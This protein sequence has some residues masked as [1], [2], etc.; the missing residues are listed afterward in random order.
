VTT[1]SASGWTEF[2]PLL[3][4]KRS[5]D[6]F[7]AHARALA[8]TPHDDEQAQA[9]DEL[10]DLFVEH[11][12]SSRSAERQS[13]IAAAL[14]LTDLAM[15]RWRIRVRSNRVAVCAPLQVADDPSAEKARIRRQELLKRDAQLRQEAVQ[16]FLRSM[17]RPR[18]FNKRFTSVF[19]LMRDGR[20]LV[21]ALQRAREYTGEDWA[22]ALANVVDPYLQFV[23]SED[24]TCAFTGLRLMDVWRYFRHTWTNQY[25]TVPGRSMAFLVRDRMAPFH[26]IVGI[27]ALSSPVMQIRER[28]KWIGWHAESFLP[29]IR[30]NP[31]EEVAKWL[32]AVVDKAIDEIYVDDLREDGIL[33]PRD[34][35]EPSDALIRR[36][37]KEAEGWR[38]LHYR[39]SRSR[40]HKPARTAP[41]DREFWIAKARTH[42]FRSKRALGLA[43][44]LRV[45]ATLRD[46]FGRK[47]TGA[48]L[49][50]LAAT[51]EGSDAIRKIVKK[52]KAD[53]VGIAVADITVCGAIQP[54]NAILGGKLV[55]MLAASPEVVAQYRHRYANAES[56]IAS[57]IAGRMV[58]RPPTLVLLGTTSLYGSGS[59]QYNRIKIPC[60]R[61]DGPADQVI[62]YEELGQS[63][64]FGTSQFSEET[65]DALVDVAQQSAGGQRVNSI[66]GEG[67]SPKLRKIRQGL[68][69]LGLPSDILLRHHRQRV[70]YAVSLVRNL[71]DYLLGID[72]EPEYLFSIDNTP[73]ASAG[74][75]AWWRERWLRNRI[76][77]D[78]VLAEV[79]KHTLVRPISHGARVL[80]PSAPL[81]QQELV[82]AEF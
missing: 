4:N 3:R 70:V 58:V 67:V 27:G 66:F 28:D 48:K 38:A 32:V 17:E 7:L 25:T 22:S 26:P 23:T 71:R 64:A 78:E 69:V 29:W 11:V 76:R 52:A 55:A 34:L 79:A 77:S 54:Y 81:E 5:R 44:L 80:R 61:L 30:A 8:R 73:T 24:A 40:D 33:T 45:R 20:E 82:F 60:D 1:A 15:Q 47:P 12:S 74:I 42:L 21:R 39:Y 62:R 46:T 9:I 2:G 19:C 36:L 6:V 37:V 18:L 56:E 31:T 13:L 16:K 72:A 59:S 50:A 65:V 75:V 41:R 10:R 14:V 68:D 49:A 53:R 35:S 63:E 43:S 51:R 57:G